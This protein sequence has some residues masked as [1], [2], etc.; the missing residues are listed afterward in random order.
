M[1]LSY[2]TTAIINATCPPTRAE[3]ERAL[4]M[5]AWSYA[6]YQ[7]RALSARTPAH[8]A[9][10]VNLMVSDL[11]MTYD[12]ATRR[13]IHTVDCHAGYLDAEE[14]L[15]GR[16]Y[17]IADYFQDGEGKWVHRWT[18]AYSRE[19]AMSPEARAAHARMRARSRAT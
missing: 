12:P 19:E 4:A 6:T 14:R 13:S 5:G 17:V 1:P 9:L 8:L 11:G 18:C 15:R 16:G 7:E 10:S 2:T 3:R